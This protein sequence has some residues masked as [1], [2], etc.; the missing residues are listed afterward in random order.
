MKIK[1]KLLAAALALLG[2][3]QAANATLVFSGDPSLVLVAFDGNEP[4]STATYVRILG[5]ANE[6]LA[7]DASNESFAAPGSS[8][9]SSTFTG[10]SNVQWDVFAVNSAGGGT[11]ISTGTASNFTGL[12]GSDV[13]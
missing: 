13:S 11:Y 12:Q 2:A 6:F 7:G 10:V 4:A 3:N 5:G 1:L 9:F 8:I